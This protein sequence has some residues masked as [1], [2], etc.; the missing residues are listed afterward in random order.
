MLNLLLNIDFWSAVC[1]FIG[2]ILWF[3]CGLPPQLNPD[4]HIH[5]ILEQTDKQE[6]KKYRIYQ[7][8]S[9]LGLGLIS[10]SFLLQI[11]RVLGSIK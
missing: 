1:G 2:T 10:L 9:Y 4:G 11:I 8:L 5:L 3:F 7:K 6:A